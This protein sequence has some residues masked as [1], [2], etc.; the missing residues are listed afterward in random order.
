MGMPLLFERS[1]D[2]CRDYLACRN[3]LEFSS[4]IL[5]VQL[6]AGFASACHHYR[7]MSSA[8]QWGIPMTFLLSLALMPFQIT[9]D[10]DVFERGGECIQMGQPVWDIAVLTCCFLAVALY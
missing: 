1:P 3:F 5:E 8:L 6:A 2:Y 9:E 10:L 7:R 4:S